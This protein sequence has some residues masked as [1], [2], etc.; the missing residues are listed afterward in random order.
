MTLNY[1]EQEDG[2]YT[3][4]SEIENM[5]RE[6]KLEKEEKISPCLNKIFYK[7]RFLPV[8]VMQF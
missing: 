3:A 4:T 2:V 5:E 1:T 7:T 8:I 6:G